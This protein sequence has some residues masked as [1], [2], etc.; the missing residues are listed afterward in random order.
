MLQR[1]VCENMDF[2]FQGTVRE[3]EADIVLGRPRAATA[4]NS[5]CRSHAQTV[6][7]GLQTFTWPAL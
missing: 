5:P 3:E 2:L 6:V 4:P 7:E 1:R